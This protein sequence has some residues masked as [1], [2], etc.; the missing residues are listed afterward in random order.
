MDDPIVLSR[1]ANHD[2]VVKSTSLVFASIR[3]DVVGRGKQ[4]TNIG[5]IHLMQVE[6]VVGGYLDAFGR[7]PKQMSSEPKEQGGRGQKETT[8]YDVDTEFGNEGILNRYQTSP[9]DVAR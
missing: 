9:I 3:T 8:L 6:R 7:G 5:I 1:R 4:L 2:G